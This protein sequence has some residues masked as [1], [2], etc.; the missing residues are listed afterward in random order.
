MLIISVQILKN[1]VTPNFPLEEVMLCYFE[2]YT[3]KGLLV[4]GAGTAER[5][6]EWGGGG[7]D[8]I[9]NFVWFSGKLHNKCFK[10]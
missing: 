6:C 9:Q 7:L 8:K 2:K 10:A 5:N 4:V 3:V 1:S